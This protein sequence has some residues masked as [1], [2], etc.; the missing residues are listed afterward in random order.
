MHYPVYPKNSPKAKLFRETFAKA[1]K[2]GELVFVFENRPYST[3]L[4]GE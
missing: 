3:K 1:Y 2:A 4:K